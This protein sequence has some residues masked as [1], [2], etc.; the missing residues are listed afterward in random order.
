MKKTLITLALAI[1]TFGSFTGC[2][3]QSPGEGSKIGQI[4]KLSKHGVFVKTWEAQL[5]RG[6][7]NGGSGSFGTTPFN[8]TVENEKDVDKIREFMENQTEV[9]ITYRTEGIYAL[10]RSDSGGDFL[11]TVKPAK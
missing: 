10:T 11:I 9:V 7:M 6:G 2:G 3:M 1:L 4:V 8:F 5:I